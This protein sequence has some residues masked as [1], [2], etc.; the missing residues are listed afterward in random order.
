MAWRLPG[1]KTLSEPIMVSL[2]THICVTRPQW[3]NSPLQYFESSRIACNHNNSIHLR[4]L[5][6]DVV[7][8]IKKE[9]S[10]ND[11]RHVIDTNTHS[12]LLTHC[13]LSINKQDFQSINLFL[14][15][16]FVDQIWLYDIWMAAHIGEKARG[17]WMRARILF[18]FFPQSWRMDG[19][20]T[21]SS[22][23]RW[24]F[25][26]PFYRLNPRVWHLIDYAH[27]RENI[28]LG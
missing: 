5:I 26:K 13:G 10:C 7:W 24:V 23:N 20:K 4:F 14:I 16:R 28:S 15:N 19:R 6:Y 22:N 27:W 25:A 17:P 18:R 3:V 21:V 8:N 2:L 9:N 1:D 12:T 11:A